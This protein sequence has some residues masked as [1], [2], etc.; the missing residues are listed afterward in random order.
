MLY[1][2][3][4]MVIAVGV[5]NLQ[6]VNL[7]NSRNMYIFGF[8]I[9]FGL[10]LPQWLGNNPGIIQTGKCFLLNGDLTSEYG[11]YSEQYMPC[12]VTMYIKRLSHGWQCDMIFEYK[13]ISHCHPCDYLFII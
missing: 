8:S 2:T 5:S 7:N 13:I 4:G 3:I 9:M 11:E 6:F 1:F 12:Y 10:V